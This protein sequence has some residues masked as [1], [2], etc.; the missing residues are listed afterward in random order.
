MLKSKEML[1]IDAEQSGSLPRAIAS[2]LLVENISK[3]LRTQA[4][5][6]KPIKYIHNYPT[7]ELYD[8]LVSE[9]YVVKDE[10]H[11]LTITLPEQTESGVVGGL[12]YTDNMFLS[13][14]EA[15]RPVIENITERIE[16]AWLSGESS[17][18]YSAYLNLNQTEILNNLG[19]RV[20]Q[21][22]DYYEIS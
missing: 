5:L 7:V 11:V 13:K 14:L 17:I 16:C 8:L 15:D 4:I 1:I 12:A 21:F 22:N 10:P 6:G 18:R 3:S 9:G 20:L 2:K 19:F